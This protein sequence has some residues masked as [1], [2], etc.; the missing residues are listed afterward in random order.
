M[1]VRSLIKITDFKLNKDLPQN[2]DNHYTHKLEIWHGDEKYPYHE[3]AYFTKDELLLWLANVGRLHDFL[4]G[5]LK[6][7]SEIRSKETGDC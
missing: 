1:N 3:A 6:D 2:T 5:Q 7:A 4:L